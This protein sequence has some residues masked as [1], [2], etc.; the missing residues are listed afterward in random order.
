MGNQPL[1]LTILIVLFALTIICAR[2]AAQHRISQRFAPDWS[3]V[4]RE[5]DGW[6]GKDGTFD[7]AYGLDPADTGLLRV[8][9]TAGGQPVIAYVGFY[10]NLATY[11]E[12]HTPEICY[13]AQGWTLLSSGR[14]A[15]VIENRGGQF[16]PEEA[17]VEKGGQRR[18]VVWW[19]YSGSRAF[20]NRMRYAYAVLI[21]SSLGG[22]RDG[23]MVRLETPLNVNDDGLGSRRIQ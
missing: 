17:I 11:M 19:Y 8:Y 20:E 23:S 2:A 12:F 13:P 7:S 1:R 18:L 21:L 6:T 4:P 22:R 15:H 16:R 14:S 10:H 5:L 9:Q 3:A